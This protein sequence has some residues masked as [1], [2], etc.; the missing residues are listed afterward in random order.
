MNHLIFDRNNVLDLITVYDASSKA[1]KDMYVNNKLKPRVLG[2]V[3]ACKVVSIVDG[4]DGAFID[5]GLK[6]NAF[7]QRNSLLR[8]LG[9]TPSKVSDEPLVKLVKKGQMFLGQVDKAPYQLKG[10][11][12]THDISIAGHMIV[13]KPFMNGIKVSKKAGLTSERD[14]LESTLKKKLSNQY[15]AILRSAALAEGIKVDAIEKELDDLIGIWEDIKKRFS[16]SASQKCL[17]QNLT[18]EA[19]LESMIRTYDIEKYY[20]VTKSDKAYLQ[21]IGVDAEKIVIKTPDASL[22]QEMGI[23]LDR[24]LRSSKFTGNEGISITVNELEA[25]TVIDVNSGKYKM[26]YNKREKVFEVNAFAAEIILQKILTFNISGVILVDFIDMAQEERLSFTQHLLEKG[27]NKSNDITI[28]GFTSLGI[29]EITRKRVEASIKDLL[30]FDFEMKDL[31][32][33]DLFNIMVDLVRLKNHTN[34]QQVMLEVETSMYQYLRQS[35]L[36]DNIGIKVKLK[37]FE[38]NQ[39]K[40]KIHT[41]KH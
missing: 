32:Y 28:E 26:D 9:I 33:W 34:T 23:D 27:Y 17:Y 2:N 6:E 37:H 16:L 41:S 39:K 31:K 14:L 36:L 35:T 13:L 1:I 4:M 20:V 10:A 29:L 25:F 18:A 19:S 40:Y 22:F 11:A 3:Y 8:A 15:G 7:I 30:S 5:I 21:T 12:I 24:Y 38:G